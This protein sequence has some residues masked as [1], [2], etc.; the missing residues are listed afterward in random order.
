MRLL[1]VTDHEGN[2]QSIEQ[3]LSQEGLECDIVPVMHEAALF[4]R[5]Q[6]D[7]FDLIYFD[8]PDYGLFTQIV[9]RNVDVP[10]IFVAKS[11]NEALVRGALSLGAYDYLI[12]D[13]DNGYLALL[14]A[15]IERV[16][17]RWNDEQIYRQAA[18]ALRESEEQ[19]R[20]TLEAM[21]D[22]VHVVDADLRLIFF[23]QAFRR[24]NKILGLETNVIGKKIFDIFPF[25]SPKVGDEYQW[26]FESGRTLVTTEKVEFGEIN[27]FTE[28]RKIPIIEAQCVSHVL[29]IVREITRK[30][31]SDEVLER[32]RDSP[33]YTRRIAHIGS[34]DTDLIT[35][36]VVWSDEMEF[37][38]GIDPAE[39]DHDF[40]EIIKRVVHPDDLD[41]VINVPLQAMGEAIKTNPTIEDAAVELP[42]IDYR[43]VLPDGAEKVVLAEGSLIFR[44]GHPIKM[45]GTLQDITDRKRVEYEFRQQTAQL[46]ALRQLGLEI[47][48]ELDLDTLLHSIVSR[49]MGLVGGSS[50]GLYLFLLGENIL[51][52]TT[53]VGP[54]LPSPG[55]ILERGEGL[56]GRIWETGQPLIIDDYQHWEGQAEIYSEFPWTSVVGV[57]I[58]W[59]PGS[60]DEGF[61]GVLDILGRPSRAFLPAD[62]DLLSLF[63]T[64]AAIAIRNARL[65]EETRRRSL[66]QETVSRIAR[67]LNTLD[68][69]DAFPVLAEGLRNLTACDRVSIALLDENLGQ[70][71]VAP[72]VLPLKPLEIRRFSSFSKTVAKESLLAGRPYLSGDI[73]KE[74]DYPGERALF[75]AGLRSRISLP[76]VVGGE[77]IGSLNLGSQQVGHFREDQLP[78]LQ[79]VADAVASAIKNSQ[80]YKIEQRK[81]EEADT[82][83]ESAL[84]L[85]TALNQ[86]EVIERILAQLQQVVPYDTCSVQLFREDTGQGQLKIV[87]GRGFPNMPEILGL[88]FL[89]GG[90]NPNTEVV[91]TR[92]TVIV[93]DAPTIYSDF[94]REPHVQA[95][96]RSW[97]GVPMLIG[98]RL[99]GLIALDRTE[100]EF[101]TQEHAQLTEVFAA[102][103]A[104]AIENARLYEEAQQHGEMMSVLLNEVNHRVKNNLTGIIGLLYVARSRAKVDDQVSYQATMDELIGRIRGLAS[105]HTM[106]SE[107]EWTPLRLTD[108]AYEIIHAALRAM[109]YGQQVLV[110]IPVSDVRVTSDQAHNLA[111]VINELTTNAMKYALEDRERAQI[112][113]RAD[114]D[115]RVICCEFRDDG[116][117]YPDEVIRLERHSVGFDLIQN[118]IKSNLHGELLLE[119]REGAVAVIKFRAEV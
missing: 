86:D 67:A 56:A 83:R 118:I 32:Y 102:Q 96:I 46:A 40:L 107:S 43:I 98:N 48:A 90:D 79:Q 31:E 1:M 35:G 104:V 73:E 13:S 23:S 105:V 39:F 61:L 84:A 49:A 37:I 21:G 70:S 38:L 36:K 117:G 52:L 50:G 80:L 44:A 115:E 71:D 22:A 15:I 75:E 42:N 24:W 110:D 2:Q 34:W 30:L 99:T 112:I 111:L 63:A 16:R 97:L 100:S 93:G 33:D 91:Q 65:Y 87:G 7:V 54:N 92:A 72:V 4:D 58:R 25:L 69:E 114:L 55:K 9:N 51:Q 6:S 3:I 74:I 12:K 19:Y 78:V 106:L 101:Y 95:G 41:L 77:V 20:V 29:T 116:P 5:L 68:V 103:A 8:L 53:C 11:G 119:N 64:Q 60:G 113:F 94:R 26:V 109:P 76:M 82:L 10:I 28:T 17:R 66:E 47:T 27:F 108:L 81:R 45:I 85:T 59:G 18:G 62:L 88:T 14:P 57:P 89:V